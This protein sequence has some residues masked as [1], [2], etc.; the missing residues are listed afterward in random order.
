MI[1]A[2]LNY[3]IEALVYM[4]EHGVQALSVKQNIADKYND[5]IQSKL[6]K[7]VWQKGGCHAWYQ[8]A[9]GKNTTLWPGFT[10]TYDLLLRHF[11]QQNYHH[12]STK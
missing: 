1:E 10:W 5:E 2:Q 12:I 6:A 9:N 7:T 3:I 4:Q 8:D 11:D